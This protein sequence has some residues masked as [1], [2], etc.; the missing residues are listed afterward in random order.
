MA[1]ARGPPPLDRRRAARPLHA[2]PPR[3]SPLT[4]A[5]SG[6]ADSLALLA[7][8]VAAGCAVTAVHVDH[9]LRPGSAAEAEV[10][11][12]A[13][14]RA[15]GRVPGRA[16][17]RRSPGPNLEARARAARRAVLPGGR[18]H[19]PH[20]GRPGRDG[21]GQPAAGRRASTGWPACAP[22]PRHPDPRPAPGR[23]RTP[24]ARTLGLDPV[25]D[26]SN[27]DPRAS[28]ATGSATSCCRCAR[29]HRRAR[30]G[31]GAG[32]PGRR[33]CATRPTCSTSSR[34]ALD[35]T[36][37][38]ARP[39]PRRRWPAG[40]RG[41]GCAAPAPTHPPDAGRGGAGAGRGPGRR[42]GPPTWP[43]GRRVR[44]SRGTLSSAPVRAGGVR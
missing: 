3:A 8:A 36:D 14:A 44:R 30:P 41:A 39:P 25:R 9:G 38:G 13:A 16:G 23:D 4:C 28:C 24:C 35:P 7:L 12:E 21:A 40:P 17:R 31:A 18:R 10:V 6:G 26:P 20:H 34:P 37:A 32:P 2:S 19:R 15:R 22:G 33:C 42:C 29:R 5:V 27:D 1:V 11:A 43:G